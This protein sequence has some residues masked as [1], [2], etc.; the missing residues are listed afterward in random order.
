MKKILGVVVLSL[1]LNST[2]LSNSK[3]T[4]LKKINANNQKNYSII[5]ARCSA[6][7][8]TE[9]SLTDPNAQ[10]RFDDMSLFIKENIKFIKFVI[11]GKNETEDAQNS[12]QFHEYYVSEY[13]KALNKNLISID[14]S[15]CTKIKKKL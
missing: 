12:I 15:F 3:L 9:L 11:P 8:V 6:I 7:Q 4:P 13:Q 2:A 14:R 5:L 10:K 1:L